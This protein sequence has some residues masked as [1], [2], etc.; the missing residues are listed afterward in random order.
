MPNQVFIH[1]NLLYSFT[2]FEKNFISLCIFQKI[3][4]VSHQNNSPNSH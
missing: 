3:H 1:N 2:N 4:V